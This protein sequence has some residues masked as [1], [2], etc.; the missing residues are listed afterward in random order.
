MA[1]RVAGRRR[2]LLVLAAV[3]ALALAG[4]ALGGVV[5]ASRDGGAGD[6]TA[7]VPGAETV[8]STTGAV[9]ARPVAW[10]RYE[11]PVDQ[12]R[13]LHNLSHGGVGVEYG[14][15]VPAATVAEIRSWYL[16]DPDGLVL[17]PLA[18]LADQIALTA[19]GRLETCRGF[20]ES[21]FSS[22]R[23]EL[24]FHGPEQVS[25]EAMRPGVGGRPVALLG[26][27]A[28][29]PER[30]ARGLAISFS[31]GHDAVLNV[32]VE[33][34]RGRPVR[35]LGPG[36]LKFAG[37]VR[38]TWDRRDDRGRVVPAG[39]YVVRIEAATE[40]ETATASARAEAGRP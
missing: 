4:A 39:G 26:G 35:I 29:A 11:R 33:D 8:T 6:C 40:G 2:R 5:L 27:L 1:G 15:E 14:P 22:F 16:A 10:G 37:T 17:A 38:M 21:V 18:R 9:H 3:G 20:D 32:E 34:D 12:R 7:G 36:A 31:L 28:V 25:R 19:W 23:D 24:R 30:F 13:L